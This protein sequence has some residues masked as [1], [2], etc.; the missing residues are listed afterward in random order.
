ML[1]LKLKH[2][3]WSISH[4]KEKIALF[5]L[6]GLYTTIYP[7]ILPYWIKK[8]GLSDQ[9]V[10]EIIEW[11]PI[12]R[13]MN[14]LPLGEQRWLVKHS[15][16]HCGTGKMAVLRGH[17]DRS[18][19]PRCDEPGEDT[20]HVVTCQHP[21]AQDQWILSNRRL[22]KWMIKHKTDPHL[23]IQLLSM[24]TNW[25][26]NGR[27]EPTCYTK[28]EY[29]EALQEQCHLGGFNFMLG[30]LS[31]KLV[32]LQHQ[33]LKTNNA[34]STGLTWASGFIREVWDISWDMWLHRNNARHD[35]QSIRNKMERE[36]LISRVQDEMDTGTDGLITD[37]HYL[38]NNPL[39]TIQT[40]DFPQIRGW[41][42]LIR[43][44]RREFVRR[45]NDSDHHADAPDQPHTDD[46][47]EIWQAT[48]PRQMRIS[49]P[50][51][52][53]KD[54]IDFSP[55]DD[56][57]S[58]HPPFLIQ[59]KLTPESF[60]ILPLIQP[61][62][63]PKEQKALDKVIHKCLAYHYFWISWG[64]F[65]TGMLVLQA[66]RRPMRTKIAISAPPR[67]PWH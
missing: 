25:Y 4:D 34:K 48:A 3:K 51:R 11:E 45:A 38:L 50:L 21:T 29:R 30:R 67:G 44:G 32:Q 65:P 62:R 66:D 43:Q 6:N 57:E 10:D 12:R 24:L 41:L 1:P 20:M 16:G 15:T 18:N 55:D 35:P 9:A 58:R 39:A 52:R 63:T 27:F 28:P 22:N 2:E 46:I 37:D 60:I 47:L 17:Q 56:D 31:T 7:N 40:W 61:T 13:Q 33:A 26:K 19:C 36:T 5:D 14:R 53:Q 23:R 54:N 49:T 64:A 42:E 8:H 59:Q